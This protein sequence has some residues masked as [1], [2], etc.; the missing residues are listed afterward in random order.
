[1]KGS[2]VSIL[3]A[4]SLC[5]FG[6]RVGIPYYLDKDT[7]KGA[8]TVYIELPKITGFYSLSI[9]AYFNQLGGTSDGTG[10][11]Q[12]AND[13]GWAYINSVDGT[14]T[15]I[16]NDTI[17]ITNGLHQYYWLYGTPSNN[18]RLELFGT[19]NDTTEVSV[20]ILLKR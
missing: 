5:S 15:A 14:V 11:L 20:N 13:T 19:V 16:P 3:L 4:L 10:Y 7:L 17:T 1:M 6:Q 8:D 18:Y 2:F 12:A 9:D